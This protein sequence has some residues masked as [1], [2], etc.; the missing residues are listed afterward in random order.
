MALTVN[1]L[2]TLSLLNILNKSSMA[3][4]KVLH[5]MATGSRINRGVDDPAGLLAL[6]KLNSELT[7]VDAGISN[8][9]RTDSILGVMDN[10]LQEIA[11][12]VSEI[13]RLA[14]ETANDAGLT[15]D[16]KLANQSQIDAALESIDRIVSSTN[17]NGKK[18]LDGSLSINATGGA[19]LNDI[20]VFSRKSGTANATLTV[21]HETA[22]SAA[23]G[24]TV[25]AASATAATVFTVQGKLGTATINVASNEKLSSV[26]DKVNAALNQTGVSAYLS[27]ADLHVRSKDKGLEAFVRTKIISGNNVNDVSDTGKDAVVTVNGQGAAVNGVKVSYTGDGV[28][29]S[30]EI[31]TLAV[32]SSVAI[33]VEGSG[34][35]GDSGATY[36]LGTTKD[37]RSTIGINGVYT[38]Q[39]GSLSDGYLTSLKSGGSASLTTDPTKAATIAREASRQIAQIQGR[40]GGFQKFQVRSALNSLSD[41]KEGLSNVRS[42]IN[43][44]DYAKANA[45]LN[46]Q[47][48]LV[49][50][51][52]SLLG[53]TNQQS[54]QVLSLLR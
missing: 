40:I 38:V 6:K 44:V 7:A 26:R 54:A 36:Q 5:Q 18:L 2:G 33:T 30:F 34:A 53:L 35:G 23:I 13:E 46:R 20:R 37:T 25:M 48:V 8:N 32:G 19:G 17:F 22:A 39:L 14:N 1:N 43:D 41:L 42:V 27:G 10:A 29:A 12:Q 28:S 4:D 15:V 16:E 49:Q 11:S 9:Q 31:G 50:S 47:N 52:I 45:E 24:A 21:K 3:Q 51:A